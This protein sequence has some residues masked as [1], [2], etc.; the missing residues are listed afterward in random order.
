MRIHNDLAKAIKS[1]RDRILNDL[2]VEITLV[3]ASEL[4]A[5]K[6]NNKK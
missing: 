5:R 1:E 4:I 2:G 6:V 3:S